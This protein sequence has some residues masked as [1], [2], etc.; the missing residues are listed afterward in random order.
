MNG[1]NAQTGFS[2]GENGEFRTTH[3]SIVLAAS[4]NDSSQAADALARLCRD[5]WYP[6]YAYIRRRGH[7]SHDAQDLTQA[8]FA[9]LLEKNFLAAVRRERGK[10]RWF[11]LATLKRFLANEWNHDHAIKRGGRHIT[12][13]LDQE[14]AEGRYRHEVADHTT[15]D[16]LFDQSWAMTVLEH[17]REQLQQEYRAGER[18]KLFEQLKIFLSGDRAPISHAEVGVILGLSES[19]VKVAVHRLRQR[20][21]DCLR[22]QIA[23]TV[24]SPAEVDDEIRQ[25]FAAFSG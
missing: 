19:A 14:T 22:E 4:G 16:K 2:R 11:L 12:I 18:E 8:F 6:L 21:R 17:A 25:L 13:S 1:E 23:Q 15:P 7:E 3:W 5:Y 9:R 20:Y 10:F 24:S